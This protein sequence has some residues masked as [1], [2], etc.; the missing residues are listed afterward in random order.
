MLGEPEVQLQ[1]LGCNEKTV[2]TVPWKAAHNH[3]P[4]RGLFRKDNGWHVFEWMDFN[5]FATAMVVVVVPQ[6]HAFPMCIS[7]LQYGYHELVLVRR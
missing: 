2:Q 6:R 1:L 3:N 4:R 5:P 7:C